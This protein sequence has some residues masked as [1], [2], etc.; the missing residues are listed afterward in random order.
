MQDTGYDAVNSV[1]V[2]PKVINGKKYDYYAM[3]RQMRRTECRIRA[4]KRKFMVLKELKTDSD[5]Q[6]SLKKEAGTDIERTKAYKQY[7]EKI[8]DCQVDS[9]SVHDR[10]GLFGEICPPWKKKSDSHLTNAGL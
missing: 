3:T 2:E 1:I 7:Q 6:K 5:R 8:V 4:F 9:D 10:L